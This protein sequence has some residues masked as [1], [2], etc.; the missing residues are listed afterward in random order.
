MAGRNDKIMKYYFVIAIGFLM[1]MPVYAQRDAYLIQLVEGIKSVSKANASKNILNTTV[2]DWSSKGKPKITLM[3]EIKRDENEYRGQNVHKFKMNQIVTYVYGNQNVGMVSKGDYF[4]SREQGIH[5]SAIEKN[6]GRGKTVSY[7][8]TGHIGN[9]EF[10]IIPFNKKTEYTAMVNGKKAEVKK[11]GVQYA[12]VTGVSKQSEII[13]S[14]SCSANNK[15]P[16]DS[17]VILNYNPQ[18]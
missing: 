17:F 7:S 16:Y 18:K 10:V 4:N 13:V 8:I 3:D 5:Y 9:Q 2:K 1:T 14:I 6:V 12:Y 15:A 11:D